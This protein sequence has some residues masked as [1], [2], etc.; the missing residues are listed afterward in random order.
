MLVYQILQTKL[1]ESNFHRI[2]E[3]PPSLFTQLSYLQH[4]DISHNQIGIAILSYLL[5]ELLESNL[6]SF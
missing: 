6:I 5:S 3:V 2:K 4:L 1:S